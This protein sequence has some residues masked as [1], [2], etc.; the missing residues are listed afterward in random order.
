VT[1]M[2]STTCR[3]APSP[4]I[5]LSLLRHRTESSSYKKPFLIRPYNGSLLRHRTESSETEDGDPSALRLRTAAD[6]P[7]ASDALRQIASVGP[8]PAHA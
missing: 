2:G 3:L 7:S 4:D 6:A 1:R 5:G 8:D